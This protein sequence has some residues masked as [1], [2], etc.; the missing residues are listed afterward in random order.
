[1][2][3]DAALQ[4]SQDLGKFM[5]QFRFISLDLSHTY[6]AFFYD[7]SNWLFRIHSDKNPLFPLLWNRIEQIQ[8]YFETI[9]SFNVDILCANSKTLCRIRS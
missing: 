4:S 2:E 3:Q 7:I 9:S 6:L 1:M 8:S 5:W